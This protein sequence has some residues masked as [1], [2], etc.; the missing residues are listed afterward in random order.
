[1]YRLNFLLLAIHFPKI[2]LYKSEQI[3]SFFP[4]VYFKNSLFLF[5]FYVPT[6]LLSLTTSTFKSALGHPKCCSVLW[7]VRTFGHSDNSK[8]IQHL[9][10]QLILDFIR[11]SKSTTRHLFMTQL[12]VNWNLENCFPQSL[13]VKL[14][15]FINGTRFCC[16]SNRAHVFPDKH[17]LEIFLRLC[18]LAEN[19]YGE[20]NFIAFFVF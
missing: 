9:E 14:Q 2:F 19:L 6:E 13:N 12:L 11:C 10:V 4:Y 17:F 7:C 15:R 8:I 1:M 5:Y 16:V 18:F 3:I 20:N